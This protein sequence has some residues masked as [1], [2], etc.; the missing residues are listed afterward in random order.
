M[1]PITDV[2]VGPFYVLA[3]FWELAASTPAAAVLL[4]ALS[5]AIFAYYN[6]A[7]QRSVARLKETFSMLNR[8]NWDED[9]IQAR[10]VFGRIKSDLAGSPGNIS[11]FCYVRSDLLNERLLKMSEAE[12]NEYIAKCVTLLTILNDYENIGLGVRHNILDEGFLYRWM[13]GTLLDDWDALSPLVAEYRQQKKRPE[14]YIEFE[15][16]AA[17]WNR[18]RSYWRPRVKLNRPNRR[19]SIN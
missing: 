8:D 10:E 11:T 6:I 14:A 7:Q 4:S 15:G 13:R 1:R 16:L 5:A 12:K 18:G 19:V 9:V 2:V 17:A 3:K